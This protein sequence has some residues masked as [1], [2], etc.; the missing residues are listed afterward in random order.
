MTEKFMIDQH[1]EHVDR[2]ATFFLEHGTD[3]E[4][5]HFSGCNFQKV[6]LSGV[7]FNDCRFD[8]CDLSLI[9]VVDTIFHNVHFNGCR[10]SGI[11]FGNCN[12]FGLE[13]QC[14]QS[15][16]DHCSFYG[17]KVNKAAFIQCSL[18]GVD[19]S[20]AQLKEAKFDGA[21]LTDAR[22]DKT[23]LEKADFSTAS[24]FQ[25]DPENNSVKGA[26]FT[27]QGLP[28]LLSTHKI[29]VVP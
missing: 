3:Y 11:L 8:N 28:G 23:N 18:K 20:G 29:R 6:S 2:S 1:F 14:Y 21:D 5:C 22:F 24:N 13:L 9:E 16:L 17:L 4:N 26:L 25:I 19:F 7:R 15:K 27:L 12:P 10:L